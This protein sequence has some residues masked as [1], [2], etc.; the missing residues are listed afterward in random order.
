MKIALA[1][2][3][4]SILALAPVAQAQSLHETHQLVWAPSGK[5]PV[6]H[7]R[8]R[9]RPACQTTQTHHQ[10]GKTAMPARKTCVAATERTQQAAR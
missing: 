6:A 2:V 4:A 7:W 3:A 8:M 10:A 5:T 9:D 1:A